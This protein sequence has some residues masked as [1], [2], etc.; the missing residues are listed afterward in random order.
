MSNF[1][2]IINGTSYKIEE[3]PTIWSRKTILRENSYVSSVNFFHAHLE[4]TCTYIFGYINYISHFCSSIIGLNPNETEKGI[5]YVPC[6]GSFHLYNT[7]W[8]QP[9]RMYMGTIDSNNVDIR[10]E[11]PGSGHWSY[12]HTTVRIRLSS[13]VY[14]YS[15]NSGAELAGNIQAS[16]SLTF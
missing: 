8:I 3:A 11:G 7:V 10:L 1:Y 12:A 16:W 15:V 5:F 9:N 13:G 2:T 4:S 6:S 14:Y